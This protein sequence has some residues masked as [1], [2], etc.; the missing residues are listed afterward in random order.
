MRRAARKDTSHKPIVEGLEARGIVVFDVSGL[1]GLG[2][3]IVC[4]RPG[5]NG[6][7]FVLELKTPVESN[8]GQPGKRKYSVANRPVTQKAAL[9]E[10]EKKA[11]TRAP[12]HV[13]E[14]LGAALAACGLFSLEK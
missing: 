12:V 9:T 13:V 1:A 3:D 4:Y 14:T 11:R 8:A 5:L 10:S 7:W 2:F 6:G